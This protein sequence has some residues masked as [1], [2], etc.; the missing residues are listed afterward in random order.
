M[1]ACMFDV[2]FNCSLQVAIK[3]KQHTYVTFKYGLKQQPMGP[4]FISI[5]LDGSE[6]LV[7]LGL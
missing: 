2:F 5:N 3:Y 6:T 1:Y 4:V 7:E